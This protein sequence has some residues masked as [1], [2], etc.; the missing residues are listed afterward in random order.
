MTE[1][2]KVVLP[3]LVTLTFYSEK[4]GITR[5]KNSEFASKLDICIA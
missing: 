4:Q 5:V 3:K 2:L 1:K